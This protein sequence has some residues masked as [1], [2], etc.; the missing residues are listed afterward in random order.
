MGRRKVEDPP[1]VDS[2]AWMIDS[3][4]AEFL[5][6]HTFE[7]KFMCMLVRCQLLR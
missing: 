4:F 6:M 5:L 1:P 7:I 3:S 2:T